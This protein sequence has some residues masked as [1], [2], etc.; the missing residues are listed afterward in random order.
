MFGASNCITNYP[1]PRE[2][3]TSSLLGN[4]L[5]EKE[6]MEHLSGLNLAPNTQT[7]H[8]YLGHGGE[9]LKVSEGMTTLIL[10]DKI[11]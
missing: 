5:I 8:D 3:D 1:V 2:S 7:Q 6:M 10:I 4:H 9:D 11:F